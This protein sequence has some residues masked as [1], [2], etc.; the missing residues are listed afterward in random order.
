MTPVSLTGTR[1]ETAA[2]E[3]VRE[4]RG[5]GERAPGKPKARPVYATRTAVEQ[6]ERLGLKGSV[7]ER[8]REAILLGHKWRRWDTLPALERDQRYVLLEGQLAAL[9]VKAPA[10]LNPKRRAWLVLSVMKRPARKPRSG[11]GSS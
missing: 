8:V 7:E 2:N 5:K 11:I 9:I 3:A 10:R 1:Q 6:A 4:S